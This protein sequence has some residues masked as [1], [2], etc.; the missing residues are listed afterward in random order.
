MKTKNEAGAAFSAEL[1]SLQKIRDLLASMKD[2][3]ITLDSI[4][5][6]LGG[7]E[8]EKGGGKSLEEK[9]TDQEKRIREHF[10]RI[11]AITTGS[12]SDQ[13]GSWGNYFSNL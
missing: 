9:L 12:L 6:N 3:G 1:E 11:R 5:G 10:D 2:E 4:F 7:D 13:I 8:D